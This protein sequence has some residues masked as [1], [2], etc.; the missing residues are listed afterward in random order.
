MSYPISHPTIKRAFDERNKGLKNRL[1]NEFS[2]LGIEIIDFDPTTTP[3]TTVRILANSYIDQNGDVNVPSGKTLADGIFERTV[4]YDRQHINEALVVS[5][6]I[7]TDGVLQT[8]I[9]FD[10]GLSLAANTALLTDDQAMINLTSDDVSVHV[11]EATEQIIIKARPNCPIY[12]GQVE[13][14]QDTGSGPGPGG[15][16]GQFYRLFTGT[17]YDDQTDLLS[18]NGTTGSIGGSWVAGPVPDSWSVRFEVSEREV[19]VFFTEGELEDFAGG[20]MA[21]CS[22]NGIDYTVRIIDTNESFSP[23]TAIVALGEIVRV[24]FT[25]SRIVVKTPNDTLTSELFPVPIVPTANGH[26]VINQDPIITGSIWVEL[27]TVPQA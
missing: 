10:S 13:V 26:I 3:N 11:I 20:F 12:W 5:G 1:V 15:G 9:P 7:N 17:Q 14:T 2:I 6:L 19:I 27:S 23:M 18:A 16:S 4:S 8:P 24:T 25:G 22:Y 21:T